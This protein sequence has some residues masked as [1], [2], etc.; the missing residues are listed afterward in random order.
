MI[1]LYGS[2]ARGEYVLWDERFDFGT[3]TTFQSDL[4]ILVVLSKGDIRISEHR[5]RDKVTKNLKKYL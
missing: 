3:H 4:D 5:L 1:I 2:Y